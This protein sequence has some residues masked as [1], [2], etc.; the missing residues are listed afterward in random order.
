[1][2]RQKDGLPQ[3]LAYE[4]RE[5]LAE[6][7]GHHVVT[8]PLRPTG[9]RDPL[10]LSVQAIEVLEPRRDSVVADRWED[11]SNSDGS[12][13]AEARAQGRADSKRKVL[14]VQTPIPSRPP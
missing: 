6:S 13:D 12:G 9:S 10:N 7:L 11:P 3:A 5:G 4:K 1:V 2:P 14:W 8:E